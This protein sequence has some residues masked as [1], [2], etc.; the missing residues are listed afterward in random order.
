M[1]TS[2]I[3]VFTSPIAVSLLFK[4]SNISV[5]LDVKS[6]L[7]ELLLTIALPMVIG[8]VSPGSR[9]DVAVPDV[10]SGRGEVREAILVGLEGLL[11]PV[12]V[13]GAL[14]EDE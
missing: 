5:T 10:H 7:M 4:S 6:I 12:F 3:G 13:H 11:V 8:Y 1:S 14:G 2:L 9:C